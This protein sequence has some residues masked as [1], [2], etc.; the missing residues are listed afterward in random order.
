M[1]DESM[2]E[3]EKALI[4]DLQ[5]KMAMFDISANKDRN[6]I[7]AQCVKDNFLLMRRAN[8]LHKKEMKNK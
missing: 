5:E 6:A 7:I 2:L 4:M 8:L 3:F 1:T